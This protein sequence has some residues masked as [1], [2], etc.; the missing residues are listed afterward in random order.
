MI[1]VYW[2]E[3]ANIKFEKKF[4]QNT[5]LLGTKSQE[6]YMAKEEKDSCLKK[7]YPVLAFTCK[8]RKIVW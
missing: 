3:I 8:S 1:F 2:L 6:Q 7:K 5:F 4:I